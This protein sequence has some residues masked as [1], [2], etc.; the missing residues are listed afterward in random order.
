M[1]NWPVIFFLSFIIHQT[2]CC[3]AGVYSQTSLELTIC[4]FTCKCHQGLYIYINTTTSYTYIIQYVFLICFMWKGPRWVNSWSLAPSRC[5][6]GS[7]DNTYSPLFLRVDR[8]GWIPVWKRKRERI[9]TMCK[10]NAHCPSKAN[11]DY[12]VSWFCLEV[13]R[14]ILTLIYINHLSLDFG[15]IFFSEIYEPQTDWNKHFSLKFGGGELSLSLRWI[16][17][18]GGSQLS[19]WYLTLPQPP[20]LQIT[21]MSSITR[22]R[23]LR[24]EALRAGTNWGSW[25]W[26]PTSWP[27]KLELFCASKIHQLLHVHPGKLISMKPE[28]H[29]IEKEYH[30]PN[31]HFWVPC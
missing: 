3:I 22:V 4:S 19:T 7:V 18:V 23:R 13:W 12:I 8:N 30:L 31:L 17:L 2:L 29:P 16:L 20:L 11:Y 5:P 1:I 14:E 24:W 10:R 25:D 26:A 15:S 9:W 28:N 27:S 6:V 21:R